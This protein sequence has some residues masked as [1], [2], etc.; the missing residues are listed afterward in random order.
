MKAKEAFH[1]LID[2]IDDEQ[3]LIGYC[4]LIEILNNN[5]IGKLWKELSA[6]VKKELLLSFDDS[7]DRKKLIS[8][9]SVKAQH[10]KWLKR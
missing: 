7:F 3:A 10:A 1:K 4:K 6:V 9:D 2:R 5:Q 8:H